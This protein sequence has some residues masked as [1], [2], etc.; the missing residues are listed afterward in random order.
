MPNVR[1]GEADAQALQ[2][3]N[4]VGVQPSIVHI[5]PY[6]LL[7]APSSPPIAPVI[8]DVIVVKRLVGCLDVVSID[9]IGGLD[10]ERPQGDGHDCLV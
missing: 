9:H 6:L 3:Q 7:S 2:R 5:P 4:D 10:C 1:V 8:K